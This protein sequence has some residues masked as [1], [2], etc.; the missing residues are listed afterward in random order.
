[1]Q[2]AIYAVSTDILHGT[3]IADNI[4][5]SFNFGEPVDIRLLQKSWQWVIRRHGLL[6]SGFSKKAG[7]VLSFR[8]YKDCETVWHPL[9]WCNFSSEE[10]SVQWN[11]LRSK[12]AA[13]SIDLTHPPLFHFHIIKLPREMH[14]FLWTCHPILLDRE[15]IFLV[16]RDWLIFYEELSYGCQPSLQESPSYAAAIGAIESADP[17][18]SCQHWKHLLQR[19][20]PLPFVAPS[21][22]QAS[23]GTPEDSPLKCEA[24]L[25]EKETTM[26]LIQ[27]ASLADASLP[28]LLA[29]AWGLVL[30]RVN[31]DGE[32]IFGIYR[33]CRRLAGSQAEESVG[34]FESCLPFPIQVPEDLT[35][36]AWLRSLQETELSTEPFLITNIQEVWNHVGHSDPC[37]QLSSTLHYL[38]ES[39]NNR[40][41]TCLPQWMRFDAHIHQNSRFP[42]Q[43]LACGRERLSIAIEYHPSWISPRIVR[44]LLERL[45]KAL[46]YFA[47]PNTLVSTIELGLPSEEEEAVCLGVVSPL[48]QPTFLD[49]FTAL[50][51]IVQLHGSRTFVEKGSDSLSFSL[52]ET[53]SSQF[54]TFLKNRSIGAGTVLALIM[55][56]SPWTLVVLLG[57]LRVGCTCLPL[58]PEALPAELGEYL[59]RYQVSTVITDRN[60][61]AIPGKIQHTLLVLEEPLWERILSLP[62]QV[63]PIASLAPTS[64]V[65]SVL[66]SNGDRRVISYAELQTVVTNAICTYNTQPND[67][68]LCHHLQGSAAA[69]EECFVALL[70]GATL[71]FP[72]KSIKSTRTA[73]QETLE[74]AKITHLRLTA[75]FWSQWLHYLA[76]LH[77][78]TPRTLHRIVIEA[79]HISRSIIS[80]W[81]EQN[82]GKADCVVFYSPSEFLGSG[83]VTESLDDAPEFCE[84]GLVCGR[85]QPS[86]AVFLVD[87]RYQLLPSYSPGILAYCLHENIQNGM[88]ENKKTVT[89]TIGGRSWQIS[90]TDEWARWNQKG[91]LVL[92]SQP[93]GQLPDSLD[94]TTLHRIE[95]ALASHP[96]IIDGIVR[97]FTPLGEQSSCLGAWIVPRDSHVASLPTTLDQHLR[98]H[99]PRQLVPAHFA[100]VTRFHLDP[101]DQIDPL[102]LATPKPQPIIPIL[103]PTTTP[104]AE[105]GSCHHLNS[106]VEPLRRLP[107]ITTLQTGIDGSIAL[108]FIHAGRGLAEDYFPIAQSLSS[109]YAVH[110][111]VV[112]RRALAPSATV[113]KITCSLA[114]VLQEY[115]SGEFALIGIGVGAI[116]AWELAHQL[117]QKN[118][119]SLSL[120]LFDI[121]PCNQKPAK[122]LQVLRR[123]FFIKEDKADPKDLVEIIAEYRAPVLQREPHFFVSGKPDPKWCQRAPMGIWNQLHLEGGSPLD[124]PAEVAKLLTEVLPSSQ[125]NP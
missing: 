104:Q 58:D 38:P 22:S 103:V 18:A 116:F 61:E 108:Y 28:I 35:C 33:S 48:V 76:E 7:D 97:S 88:C 9:N 113:E 8:E 99:L 87:S 19:I 111:L 74:S 12:D 93:Y 11:R 44:Q 120:V 17:A 112:P 53:Y 79:G 115:L 43:V 119:K 91:Q 6:R 117:D 85:P 63:L 3:T 124:Q 64:P 80:K 62:R 107:V 30:G 27:S 98:E 84:M 4:Q 81:K 5:I 86:V 42:M 121:P 14:H 57:A 39:L 15:S 2:E 47:E 41:H 29:A 26:Q 109:K 60:E 72:E 82:R 125:T 45:L 123:A 118:K 73:F 59:S 89:A 65:V 100:L 110:C 77:H 122:W 21:H 71:I 50:K 46:H 114:L 92:I 37:P 13:E 94:W 55:P 96:D 102:S 66:Q 75:A 34:L 49:P 95:D 68:I 56:L 51:R 20:N 1:M 32:A 90:V 23:S 52:M 70:T 101:F 40:I 106:G 78:P 67:R 31:V 83:I 69:V 10:I 54:S 24:F 16:L 105:A 36:E 25:L